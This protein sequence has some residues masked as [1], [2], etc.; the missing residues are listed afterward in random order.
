MDGALQRLVRPPRDSREQMVRFLVV[1]ACGYLLAILVYAAEIE[2]GVSPYL[3]VPPIIVV[4]GVFNFT[5]NRVWTFPHSGR[6]VHHDFA[7]FAL[8]V[9]VSLAANY[10]VL[11][12]L[13]SVAGV[14]PVLAQSL[15]IAIATPVSFLG[16]K[17]FSF[18]PASRTAR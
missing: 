16:N 17:L 2:M 11:Y 1:G 9:V 12:L 3:A 7:R 18:S 5:L 4:N 8:V 13:H 6:P 14:Q 10:T 15:A